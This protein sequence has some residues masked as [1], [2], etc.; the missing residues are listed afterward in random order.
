MR[1]LFLKDLWNLFFPD[2]CCGCH[3]QLIRNETL[4]CV[5]CRHDLPF[6][7]LSNLK[8]NSLE[9]AFYGRLPITSA[10]AL[11]TFHKKGK[12]QQLIHLLKYQNRQDIGVFM[13]TLLSRELLES[14]RF[15]DIDLILPVPLHPK[16]FKKRGYNQLTLFGKEM[17]K[18]LKCPYE[19]KI[20]IRTASAKTQTKSRRTDRFRNTS[21]SFEVSDC[22]LLENKH[23]LLVDDVITTGATLE[24]CC[25]AL[26]KTKNVQL[27]IAAIACPQEY[28]I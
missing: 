21:L 19:E 26:L 28:C 7:G 22:S 8:D 16:Q 3:K 11:F 25:S 15:Q 20:L 14:D 6:A 2:L 23:V 5:H 10:T 12:I 18:N 9:R 13:G 27:S 4:L 24:A 1:V 17:A